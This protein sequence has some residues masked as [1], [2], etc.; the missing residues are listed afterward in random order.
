MGLLGET[1]NTMV[2]GLFERFELSK[3][4]SLSTIKSLKGDKAGQ[5]VPVT[6]LFSDIRGFT[7]FSEDKPPETVVQYLNKVLNIQTEI[8]HRNGGDIDKYVGDEVVALFS[9]E[10]A[11]FSACR[12]AIMI[13]NTFAENSD[14]EY[15]GLKVGIGINT[16]DVIL[17]MIGSE[18]RADFT[19]IGDNVN[20]ASRL[21][22][23]AK[24][25]QILISDSTFVPVKDEINTAG[26][27]RLTVKGKNKTLRVYMLRGCRHESCLEETGPAKD[28]VKDE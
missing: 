17:G 8:I 25:G 5:N 11:E 19:T 10:E 16:G 4:V 23:A 22:S 18:K 21:C 2:E 9:G 28:L 26:P 12:A 7:S 24:M 1:V 20:T 6:L 13:Q 15:G 3:F 27:Y 14:R